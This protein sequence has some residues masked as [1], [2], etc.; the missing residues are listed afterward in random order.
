MGCMKRWAE[1]LSE[2]IG[3]QGAITPRVERLDRD[4]RA[5]EQAGIIVING[6]PMDVIAH[7]MVPG[8][9]SVGIGHHEVS[10]VG[11]PIPTDE[12]RE[13]AR[14]DLTKYFREPWFLTMD[15]QHTSVR[16]NDECGDCG[17]RMKFNGLL[18]NQRKCEN[19]KCISNA[20]EEKEG[21]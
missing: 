11:L 16:F 18:V 5:L 10:V 3:L 4:L 14:Q 19:P 15:G 21:T 17:T 8:D 7:V 2:A 6:D 13:Q 20:P 12:D 1:C 9:P